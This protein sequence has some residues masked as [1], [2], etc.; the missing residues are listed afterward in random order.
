MNTL[1]MVY[2]WVKNRH[3]LGL[4]ALRSSKEDRWA[5]C[6][7]RAHYN[8]INIV[9][10]FYE[11]RTEAIAHAPQDDL[12]ACTIGRKPKAWRW[13]K[14]KPVADVLLNIFCVRIRLTG[15]RLIF[16][17]CRHNQTW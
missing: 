6:T 9:S 1:L 16:F 11:Q 14:A 4:I 5:K 3:T 10:S 2:C 8:N 15:T 12:V 13:P 7:R 17:H